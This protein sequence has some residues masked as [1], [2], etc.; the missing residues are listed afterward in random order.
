[1]ATIN[2]DSVLRVRKALGLTQEELAREM[3]CS[4]AAVQKYEQQGRRPRNAALRD[5]LA[6]L[7]RRAGVDVSEP[8]EVSA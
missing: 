4:L 3:K 5:N 7:A 6:R 2:D 8:Q 1:M